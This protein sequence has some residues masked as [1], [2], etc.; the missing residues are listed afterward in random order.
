MSSLNS[1]SQSHIGLNLKGVGNLAMPETFWKMIG[2]W[3]ERPPEETQDL[4]RKGLDR[5][6]SDT[7]KRS[8]LKSPQWSRLKRIGQKIVWHQ[9]TFEQRLKSRLRAIC[10]RVPP[11]PLALKERIFMGGA[12]GWF[13]CSKGPHN[14]WLSNFLNIMCFLLLCYE[15]VGLT[16]YRIMGGSI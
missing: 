12:L 15:E 7:E 2:R 16:S 14:S 9:I 10:L 6:S 11:I 1:S 8:K 3:S 13:P 4:K 5:R